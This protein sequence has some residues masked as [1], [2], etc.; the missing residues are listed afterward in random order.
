MQDKR[1]W[2]G[3]AV[4]LSWLGLAGYMFATIEAPSSLNEWGDSFAGFFAPLAFFWLVLGYLQQGEELRLSTAALRLQAE[5]LKNSV[6]Q[7]IELV[8]IGRQQLE[9]EREV[10][11][12]ERERLRQSARPKLIAQNGGSTTSSASVVYR[13]QL[14]NFG[15][16]ATGLRFVFEPPLLM[17]SSSALGLMTGG[18]SFELHL[19]FDA[20]QTSSVLHITFVDTSSAS[21]EVAIS[22]AANG[23]SL[24]IGETK[25]VR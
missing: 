25:T 5:E 7:Q 13:L 23:G 18:G 6:R 16:N 9:Q 24:T 10:L 22:I 17:Q 19:Q 21:G 8:A 15:A 14:L 1:F 11:N 12:E 3:V 20:G 4:S 2:F